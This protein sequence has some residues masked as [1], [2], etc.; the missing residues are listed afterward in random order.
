[1][2]INILRLFGLG[3]DGLQVPEG[4]RELL[5]RG[6]G[7]AILFK[8]NLESLEQ[9]CRLTADL[10]TAAA[11]PLLIG[12]DQEG[13][14]VTRLPA[15]FLAPPSAAAL[16][17]L[18]DPEFTKEVARAVG[19]ELLA[20]GINWNLAPVL[21]IHTN[22]ANPVIGDRAYGND[23]A[24]VT[25]MGLAALGGLAEA[26]V[27]AT[28]K[29]FPGHGDTTVDSHL[30]LPESSQSAS[31]W[32]N[33]EF[34]PFRAAIEADVPSIMVAHLN[35][36]ALDAHA[37]TSLSRVVL[38]EILRNELGFQGAVVSDD[39]EMGAI[40]S[41]FDIG[42]AAVR[43]IE[44]GGD[45]ILLCRNATLQRAAIAAVQSAV[46]LKRISEARILESE[47]RI[48]LARERVGEGNPADVDSVR[49]M[50][51][52]NQELLRRFGR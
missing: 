32:R 26:G 36:P 27:L 42:E 47:R 35:C 6:L 50:M 14:R 40:A 9:I 29:H 25:R 17:R 8:R 38:T 43:F 52:A 45:S 49:Q 39:M 41:N 20:V 16:G 23:P 1:M 44:A 37:P 10:R 12:L 31:R 28:A 19:R 46:R 4:I 13:G 30:T 3:F 24:L 48:N 7:G 34:V 11:A 2:P 33:V 15:P 22:P 21:D 51:A 18:G 5:A